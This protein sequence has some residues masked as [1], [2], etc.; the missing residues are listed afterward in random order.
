MAVQDAVDDQAKFVAFEINAIIANP[1][2][3]QTLAC[4][5]ELAELVQFRVHGSS[6]QSAELAKYLQL[7]LLR[8]TGQLGGTCR[9]KDNLKGWHNSDHSM[10]PNSCI[11]KNVPR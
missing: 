5:F 2:A 4:A 11:G 3:V 10:H 6:R 1:K 7:K 8:H 9:V